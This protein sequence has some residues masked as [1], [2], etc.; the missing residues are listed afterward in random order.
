M[1]LHGEKNWMINCTAMQL[2][3]WVVSC[4][5]QGCSSSEAICELWLNC[6]FLIPLQK[7]PSSNRGALKDLVIQYDGNLEHSSLLCC[8]TETR[9]TRA[10]VWVQCRK[11]YT[12]ICANYEPREQTGT[13]TQL[14]LC[15]YAH[16]QAAFQGLLWLA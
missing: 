4:S 15:K 16:L 12:P 1:K 2:A 8:L 6:H 10:T 3:G 7:T 11:K 9:N 13:D 14:Q 5:P